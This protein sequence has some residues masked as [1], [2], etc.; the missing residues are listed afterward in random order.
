TLLRPRLRSTLSLHDALPISH[1]ASSVAYTVR[2]DVRGRYEVGPLVV[3]LTDPF[4]LC[5]LTRSFASI[6]RL[7]VIP[8]VLQLPAI[9]LAGERS[10]EHTSELQSR[11]DLVRRLL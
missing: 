4:G 3:R 2:A 1:Q 7:T 6:D 8:Q 5:E 9:R 10:E 11:S